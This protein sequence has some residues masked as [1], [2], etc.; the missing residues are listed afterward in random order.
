MTARV[1]IVTGAGKG[2]GR[3]YAHALARDRARVVVNNR[4]HAGETD[5]DT[6]AAR[7][8]A[9]IRAEGGEAVAS[10]A[11]VT[12]P[13]SGAA[14]VAQA[15]ESFGRIDAV[16]ANAGV[17]GGVTFHK[18][19]LD[20]FKRVFDVGFAGHL[21][22]IHAAWPVMRAQRHG[23]IVATTSSAGLHGEHGMSA[24]AASKAAVIGLVRA[25]ALEGETHD[26]RVNAIAPYAT[27]QMTESWLEPAIAAR[28]APERVAPMV[29]WL[30]SAECGVSG[31]VIVGGGGG[32]R[33]A[34]AAES[35]TI[36]GDPSTVAAAGAI[37]YT[38][39]GEPTTTRYARATASF[40]RLIA[41]SA[42]A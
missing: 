30:A 14:M 26:I 3:A 8:V 20:E 38:L 39:V 17:G 40:E 12:D 23:R 27:T 28:L 6:S 13:A 42:R 25:L 41:E 5:A 4:R 32:W 19:G 11:D 1:V 2:L 34:G 24:Y 36:R 9:E 18:M 29:A 37:A 15:L 16:V 10:H 7:V 22:L 31:E 35:R 33:R 21:H